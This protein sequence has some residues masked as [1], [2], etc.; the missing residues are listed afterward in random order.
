M[1][2]IIPNRQHEH[3][4]FLGENMRSVG[5]LFIFGYLSFSC[6]ST[7]E[8]TNSR[9]EKLGHTSS[10]EQP[11]NTKPQGPISEDATAQQAQK[12]PLPTKPQEQGTASQSLP[13]VD[14][15]NPS[16]PTVKPEASAEDI[17]FTTTAK[18]MLI[19]DSITQGG[20]AANWR[21]LLWTAL[22]GHQYF[23]SVDFVGSQE[24]AFKG[25]NSA[26]KDRSFDGDHQGHFGWKADAV[27]KKVAES[28]PQ[29]KPDIALIHLGT[30]DLW[31]D[32]SPE[33]THQDILNI[34]KLL[35]NANPNVRIF[36]AGIIPNFSDASTTEPTK[37]Y[38]ML[39]KSYI[40]QAKDSNLVYVEFFD[41]I[42]KSDT[43]DGVHPN[44]SG[45]QIFKDVWL[46]S[47]VK[48]FRY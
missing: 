22:K 47:L 12:T 32:D 29:D 5:F 33:S 9:I 16:L 42:K 24:R 14:D 17:S 46:N 43:F 34:V 41:K 30:N 19:G 6:G 31:K 39:N 13:S 8:R 11:E 3:L 25:D 26:C 4:F 27:A 48:Y 38:N 15:E 23:S 36:V 7:T 2:T 1:F 35:K 45:D 21:C 28:A 20:S 10:G 37:K 40:E 18:I 44:P